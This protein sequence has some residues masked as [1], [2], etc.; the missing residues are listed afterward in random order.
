M[1]H[2]NLIQWS[3]HGNST[4]HFSFSFLFFVF[5]PMGNLFHEFDLQSFFFTIPLIFFIKEKGSPF[6]YRRYQYILH[7]HPRVHSNR[8]KSCKNQIKYGSVWTLK[9]LGHR[10]LASSMTI[11]SLCHRKCLA[12]IQVS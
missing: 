11:I 2:G 7:T 5:Y 3:R 1:V 8:A 4:S 12:S 10:S 9:P 6:F